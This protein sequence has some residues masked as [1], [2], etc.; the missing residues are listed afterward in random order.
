MGLKI[1]PIMS[2]KLKLNK[3]KL[4]RRIENIEINMEFKNLGINFLF[5]GQSPNLI[6]KNKGKEST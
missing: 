2:L 5:S 6:T 1:C 3:D 4:V